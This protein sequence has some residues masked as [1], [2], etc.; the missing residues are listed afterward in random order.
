MK[1]V[2]KTKVVRNVGK[3]DEAMQEGMEHLHLFRE[4]QSSVEITQ[5]AKGS[6]KFTV[7]AYADTIDKAADLSLKV[8]RKIKKELKQ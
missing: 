8:H 5:D 2:I 4:S 6:I 3:L 1:T 7:K